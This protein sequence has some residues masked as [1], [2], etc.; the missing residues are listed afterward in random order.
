MK[1]AP[2]CVLLGVFLSLAAC[3]TQ[4]DAAQ[5]PW[6][7]ARIIVWEG[8]CFYPTCTTYQMELAPDGAYVLDGQARTKTNGQS[9]GDLGPAAWARAQAALA[10]ANFNA[11]PESLNQTTIPRADG[12]PCMAHLPGVRITWRQ[13]AA[14]EKTV[15]W[16]RGCPSET[17][18]VLVQELHA[19]MAYDLLIKPADGR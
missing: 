12:M 17:A 15:L 2:F 1:S 11:L 14:Q 18:S 16:D 13:S 3:A 7:E 19:A 10:K 9:R 4:P 5:A 8:G 6:R